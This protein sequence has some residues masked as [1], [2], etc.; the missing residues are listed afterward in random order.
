M[1]DGEH[2]E[3]LVQWPAQQHQ[4]QQPHQSQTVDRHLE[5]FDAGYTA[6]P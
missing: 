6:N 5:Q 1:S 4:Q 3:Q 2:K